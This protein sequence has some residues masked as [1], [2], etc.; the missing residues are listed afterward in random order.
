MMGL[1]LVGCSNNNVEAPT[2]DGKISGDVEWWTN[3]L[4]KGFTPYLTNLISTFEDAHP[5]VKIKWVDVAPTDMSRKYLAAVASG[6][7]PDAVNLSSAEIG[8]FRSTLADLNDYFSDK[9]LATYQP[10][11]AKALKT[12]GKQYGVPWY[13]GGG[14]ISYYRG[15]VMEKVG[16]SVDKPATSFDDTLELAQEV[17]STTGTYGMNI[18]FLFTLP[19]YYGV[20]VLN[21]D[22]TKAAFNTPEMVK[23]LTSLKKYYDSGALAPGTIA[24][25]WH[26]YPQSLANK[27]IAFM[28]ANWATDIGGLKQNAPEVYDD[29]IVA[30]GPTSPDGHAMLN[31]QQTYVI[32]AKSKNKPAAAEW[33][34]FV[35]SAQGQLEFCKL[36]AIYPSTV[37]TLKDSFFT[38]SSGTTATDKARELVVSSLSG[39]GLDDVGSYG[40]SHDIE[41]QDVFAEQIRAALSGT[42]TAEEALES[43]EEQWNKILG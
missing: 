18:A 23:V 1:G 13:N 16:F 39:S 37:A 5:D 41:L 11:L 6:S 30:P 9:D 28:P 17:K 20:P 7:V 14:L 8:A 33:I 32:P 25:D 10:G 15:S 35:T 29:L 26:N 19:Y 34:K 36:V 3:N 4:S 38:A 24:K 40:T 12:D 21:A 22:R 27:Q 42:K 31:G 2:Q 43:A